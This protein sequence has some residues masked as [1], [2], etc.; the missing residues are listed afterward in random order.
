MNKFENGIFSSLRK[1]GAKGSPQFK[2]VQKQ[3]LSGGLEKPKTKLTRTFL[4]NLS[5]KFFS[6]NLH[7]L[8]VELSCTTRWVRSTLLGARTVHLFEA[9]QFPK[10]L[11]LSYGLLWGPNLRLPSAMVKWHCGPWWWLKD[12]NAEIILQVNIPF[13]QTVAVDRIHVAVIGGDQPQ[14]IG[15]VRACKPSCPR[16]EYWRSRNFSH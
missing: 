6:L 12:L 7:L 10:L 16:F 3:L 9:L 13:F 8:F 11:S 15:S 2:V 14:H 5:K 4:V 1:D